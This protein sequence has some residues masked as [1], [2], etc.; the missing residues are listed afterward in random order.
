[1]KKLIYCMLFAGIG[2]LFAGCPYSSNFAID[3]SP[4]IPVNDKLLGAWEIRSSTDYEYRITKVD[5]FKYQIDKQAKAT[6][7]DHTTYEAFMSK[8]D[9][10]M[11]LNVYEKS[12]YSPTF[13]F[14][15]VNKIDDTRM[16]L[17]AVT[18]N[19]DEIFNS[20]DEVRAYFT[21]H[22]K[23]SFFYETDEDEYLKVR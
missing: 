22:H 15:K 2:M 1:M 18:S 8:I 17:A 11:F 6:P 12:E 21:K 16:S 7:D 13:Y 10:D 20:S 5:E 9:N 3:A 23:L 14:Y 4:S 19:I